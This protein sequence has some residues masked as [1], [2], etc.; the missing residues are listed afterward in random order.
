L[1]RKLTIITKVKQRNFVGNFSQQWTEGNINK[2]VI[3]ILQVVQLQKP[4]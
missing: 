2:I 1:T 4:C 3:K